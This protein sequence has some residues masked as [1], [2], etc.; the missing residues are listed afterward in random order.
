MYDTNVS[1]TYYTPEVF[2]ETDEITE[3]EKDFIRN[4]IYRQEL[5]D[6]FDLDDFDQ[7]KIVEEIQL[8]YE[9]IQ[10]H[11]EFHYLLEKLEEKYIIEKEDCFLLLFS[12]DYLYKTHLCL[13]DYF[14]MGKI[15]QEHLVSLL[16][17]IYEDSLP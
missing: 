13:C 1:M 16:A 10:F 2:L 8:V 5:L 4:C 15:E 3:E 9:E 14:T 6:L 12:F 11:D 7:Q 17:S